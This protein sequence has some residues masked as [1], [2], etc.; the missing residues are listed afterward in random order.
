MTNFVAEVWLNSFESHSYLA[1]AVGTFKQK[2]KILVSF[3]C[4]SNFSWL[5]NV[6][7]TLSADL[8]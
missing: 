3:F 5:V 4:L 7:F 2:L 1:G 8:D 6:Y